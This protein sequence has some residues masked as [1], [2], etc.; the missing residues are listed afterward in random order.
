[1][2][3]PFLRME[4]KFAKLGLN[5]IKGEQTINQSPAEITI[6]QPHAELSIETIKGKLSI[7]QSKAWEDM[8]LKSIKKRI[9]EFAQNGFQDNME[10][11]ARN[12]QQGDQLMKIE[13]KGNVIAIQAESNSRSRELEF[14][15]GWVP[16]PFSVR[17]SYEPAILNIN[18]KLNNPIITA[19]VN[20]PH[21]EYVS[22]KVSGEMLQY[23]ELN[24]EV[25]G[26]NINTQK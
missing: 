25:V 10:G 22:G 11:I 21:I 5:I 15:I 12:A 24:I 2:D 7:D 4:S 3:F 19:K 1:M 23:P 14:N 17:I 16:S 20:K 6:E 13:N 26:L 18:W 9:E 8:D